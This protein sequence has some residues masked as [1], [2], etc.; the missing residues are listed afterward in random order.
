MEFNCSFATSIMAVTASHTVSYSVTDDTLF[1][2][3][4][5]EAP[6]IKRVIQML[7]LDLAQSVGPRSWLSAAAFIRCNQGDQ[8]LVAPAVLE[9]CHN[10]PAQLEVTGAEYAYANT[11]RESARLTD[12]SITNYFQ[13]LSAAS[14]AD[15]G[16][17]HNNSI[18]VSLDIVNATLQHGYN[19]DFLRK[20][21]SSFI[22]MP[23]PAIILMTYNCHF[24]RRKSALNFIICSF[25]HFFC[26]YPS[27]TDPACL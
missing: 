24:Q 21:P 19:A 11:T 1:G 18:F 7:A 4:L 5:L 8:D 14:L 3:P 22:V 17:W 15:T 20:D 27:V 26:L 12:P 6:G 23:T 2:P 9:E 13:A 10:N 25:T 16:I